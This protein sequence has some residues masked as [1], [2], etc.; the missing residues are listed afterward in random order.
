MAL[1]QGYVVAHHRL[2]LVNKFVVATDVDISRSLW[3]EAF[4]HIEFSLNVTAGQ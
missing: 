3:K 1:V 4:S 2:A